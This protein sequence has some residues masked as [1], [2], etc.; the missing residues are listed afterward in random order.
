MRKSMSFLY[1]K[2]CAERHDIY[3]GNEGVFEIK[4]IQSTTFLANQVKFMF[5]VEIK[6]LQNVMPAAAMSP[7]L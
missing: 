3:I 1:F 5:L 6:V 7:S 2:L 4:V